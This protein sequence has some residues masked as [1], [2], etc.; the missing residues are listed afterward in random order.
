MIPSGAAHNEMKLN[1]KD[2][3]PTSTK[4]GKMLVQNIGY[5]KCQ[6]NLTQLYKNCYA[7]VHGH[8]FGGTNP[9]MINALDLNCNIIALDTKFNREMLKRKKA[10][11]FNKNTNSLNDSIIESEKIF[12][13]TDNKNLNYKMPKIYDWDYIAKQYLDLFDGITNSRNK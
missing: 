8:E 7:Y 2:K 6:E 9:T 10:I 12:N 13:L 3:V 4:K 5:V 1:D 11:F